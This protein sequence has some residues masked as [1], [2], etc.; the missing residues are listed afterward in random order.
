MPVIVKPKCP[1]MTGCNT[2]TRRC[3]LSCERYLVYEKAVQKYY[4]DSYMEIRKEPEPGTGL[5]G[6]PLQKGKKYVA[7]SR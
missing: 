3:H 6:Y 4:E 1:C 5:D 7:D 2:R